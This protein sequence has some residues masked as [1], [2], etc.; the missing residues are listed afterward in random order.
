M[1]MASSTSKTND[2]A[3]NVVHA[4]VGDHH[5]DLDLGQQVNGI[6]LPAIH[7]FM[8]LLPSMAADLGDRHAFDSDG[9]QRFLHF[10]ELERL[11]NCLNLLHGGIL[12]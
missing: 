3:R 1:R 5:F 7:L 6:F 8:A 2:G 10:V 11:D 9:L 12:N 4:A